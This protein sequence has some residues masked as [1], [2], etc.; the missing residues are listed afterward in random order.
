L[1]ST[2]LFQ[3]SF[4]KMGANQDDTASSPGPLSEEPQAPPYA[5]PGHPLGSVTD[6]IDSLP[7][8]TEHHDPNSPLTVSELNQIL[9]NEHGAR[10]NDV[11]IWRRY[12]SSHG[13]GKQTGKQQEVADM[14]V[15]RNYFL[16]IERGQED[17]IALLIENQ[18]VTANT[19]MSEM[20]PL[21]FAISKRNVRVVQQLL[22]LGADPNEFGSPVS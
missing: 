21:L 22:N 12:I 10:E 3:N 13:S 6:Q 8:Y 19:K 7:I 20:T 5:L 1:E 16:A 14:F 9:F 11:N 2:S 17:V 4:D 18:L 15:I